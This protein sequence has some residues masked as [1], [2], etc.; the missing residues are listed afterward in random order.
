[1][2]KSDMLWAL[3]FTAIFS[4]TYILF[5]ALVYSLGPQSIIPMV[6]GTFISYY[7]GRHDV[8]IEG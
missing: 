5:F 6:I 4:F 1:M 8:K 3:G 2:V 7:T